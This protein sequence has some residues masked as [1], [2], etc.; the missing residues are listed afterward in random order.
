MTTSRRR[1]SR[2]VASVAAQVAVSV[3]A[4]S[5]VASAD[6]LVPEPDQDPFYGVPSGIA[7]KPNGAVLASRRITA[8]ALSVPI[9]AK[10]WQVKYKTIDQHGNP[11]AYVATVL[12]P[13]TAWS[14]S[15]P[16]PL[17]SYQAAE[18]G[19]ATR[20]TPSYAL[21]AGLAAGPTNSAIETPI[22]AQAVAR[23]FAVVVPD[24]Q[25]PRSEFTGAVGSAHGVLDGI[26][27]AKRFTPAGI[28]RTARVGLMGYSGGALATDWA[29]QTQPT[30]APGLKLAGAAMGGVPADVKATLLK[31][32]GGP[33]GGALAVAFAGM[34]RSYPGSHFLQYFN[35]EGKAAIAD[36]QND[37]L[38][39]GVV[40]YPFA[41]M[42]KWGARPDIVDDP[43]FNR[44]IRRPSPLRYPGT[45][46][47]RVLFYHSVFDELAPVEK[48]R[49]LAARFCA[50]GVAVH[51][52][53]AVTGNHVIYAG[54]GAV[55]AMD[56]LADRFAGKPAPNDCGSTS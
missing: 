37:C 43:D 46:S 44:V 56:Y 21:R 7:G 47:T 19:V 51:R 10:A 48:M 29:I 8:T 30:Y 15:G 45:P 55:S 26:R 25:G 20:C 24:Y 54:A 41:S 1:W 4:S 16:R 23:G 5:G 52:V 17:L 28:G 33:Q 3:V 38:T 34:N 49:L 31:F 36:S 11:S 13:W 35:K 22:I 12:I 27:A 2:V 9:P 14:G 32:S 53:E 50:R 39:D 40:K 6:V 18:D 42:E